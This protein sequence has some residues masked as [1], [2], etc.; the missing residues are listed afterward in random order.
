MLKYLFNFFLFTSLFIAGCALL[1]VH[2]TNQL[3]QLHYDYTDYLL[4]VFFS[5]LCSYNFHWFL[6]QDIESET[7]RVRWTKAHKTL[8]LVLTA[9]GLAGAAWYF[10]Q[11]TLHWMWLAGAVL[12]TFLYSAPKISIGP[13][14]HLKKIAVGK[15]LFLAFVWTYVTTFLP[16]AFD[17]QHWNPQA[18][19]FGGSRFFLIYAICI[20]FDYRDRDFDRKEGIRSMITYLSETGIHI[21][22]FASLLLFGLCTGLLYYHGF[23]LPTIL[24]L[25]IPGL[26][27]IP[28]YPVARKN[29]SDYLY[30][31]VLDGLMMLSALFTI[32]APWQ[33]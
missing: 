23:S 29:F 27:L 30:Y 13:F 32:F 2:Q 20:L 22:F 5:T 11:L 16:L 24:L 6:S 31:F 15:T 8:H 26:I 25:L 4:F 17:E 33:W 9:I 21:L 3:L 7:I 1:M 28:L 19:L 14:R 10:F 18:F 12:L